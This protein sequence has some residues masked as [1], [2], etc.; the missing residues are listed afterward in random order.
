MNPSAIH[1]NFIPDCRCYCC[2]ENAIDF[3]P[4]RLPYH[5]I[6]EAD[7]YAENPM[8]NPISKIMT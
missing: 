6:R 3:V 8:Y 1:G 7:A 4:K 2:T 5:D